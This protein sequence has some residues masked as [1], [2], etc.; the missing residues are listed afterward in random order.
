MLEV[1]CFRTSTEWT[2]EGQ[3]MWARE[4]GDDMQERVAGWTQTQA[5]AIRTQPCTWGMRTTKW[6][7]RHP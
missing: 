6:A 5:T 7:N 4:R 2:D 1:F 3:K